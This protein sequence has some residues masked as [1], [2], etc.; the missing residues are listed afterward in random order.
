METTDLVAIAALLQE[1]SSV[2][3]VGAA[4]ESLARGLPG[5]V[6]GLTVSFEAGCDRDVLIAEAAVPADSLA[7]AVKPGGLLVMMGVVERPV[8]EL[9]GF[10][11]AVAEWNTTVYRKLIS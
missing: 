8:R 2:G 10:E 1:G 7:D 3:A 6:P 11:F 9:A 5:L 4:A